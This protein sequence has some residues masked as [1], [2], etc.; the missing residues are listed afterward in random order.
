M[1]TADPIARLGPMSAGLL[2]TP[3]EFDAVTE[4]D[5]LYRYELVRGVLVV[6]P[7]ADE[8]ERACIEVAGHLL[9]TYQHNHPQGAALDASIYGQYVRTSNGC[10]RAD[11]VI[12]V[13]LGRH[14][15]PA[16]DVPAIVMDVPPA[17]KAAS[18]LDY[19][20]RRA[21]Y[22]DAGVR[23][24]WGIDRFRRVMTVY[25]QEGGQASESQIGEGDTFRTPLLPGFELP[26][27]RILAA[28]DR[29]K[30]R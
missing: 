2:M 13:G 25:R 30:D 17:C 28:A 14:P 15:N 27:A 1:T 8:A 10:R 3:D 7:F 9:Q 20:G 16:F 26:L 12:W 11:R 18:R 4:Y 23:E 29:W 24:Y 6:T 22:I 5:E 21:E 19:I